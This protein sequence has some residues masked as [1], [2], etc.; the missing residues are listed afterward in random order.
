MARVLGMVGNEMMKCPRC[1][2]ADYSRNGWYQGKQRYL[3]KS[4]G[5]QWLAAIVP[6]G[7]PDA[8]RQLCLKMYR[9]GLSVKEMQYYTNIS[10]STLLNWIKQSQ[11][12]NA[13]EDTQHDTREAN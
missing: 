9:N 11:I 2:A 7:Y 1:N 4:C 8:V 12:E 5:R 10:Q 3:C 6:R 13:A